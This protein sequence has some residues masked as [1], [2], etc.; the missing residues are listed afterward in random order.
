MRNYKCVSDIIS[1]ME[2]TLDALKRLKNDE[3]HSYHLTKDEKPFIFVIINEYPKAI[4]FNENGDGVTLCD[5]SD[6]KCPFT[7]VRVLANQK[8]AI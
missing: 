5:I 3:F 8:V 6:L 2:K 7:F 1:D 4:V